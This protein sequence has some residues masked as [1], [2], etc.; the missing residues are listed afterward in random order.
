MHDNR[1]DPKRP[2]GDEK[3]SV[4]EETGP[5]KADNLSQLAEL[6]TP[7]E[8]IST[9]SSPSDDSGISSTPPKPNSRPIPANGT[10]FNHLFITGT[11]VYFGI[12]IHPVIS[13]VAAGLF[14]GLRSKREISSPILDN[15][16]KR[17]FL[18]TPT[19]YLDGP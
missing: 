3:P 12:F 6:R 7:A 13:G 9:A 17:S 8:R 2:G 18:T 4:I 11:A 1:I 10:T 16:G 15:E 19:E 5:P 14:A